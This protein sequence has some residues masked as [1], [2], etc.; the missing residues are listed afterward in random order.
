MN[1]EYLVLKHQGLREDHL[2]SSGGGTT[3]VKNVFLDEHMRNIC[4]AVAMA[5]PAASSGK[6]ITLVRFPSFALFKR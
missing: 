6:I 5:I 1:L 4:T 3:V 2:S